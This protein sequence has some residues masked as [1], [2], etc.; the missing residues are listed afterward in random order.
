M[1][2][3]HTLQLFTK[4]VPAHQVVCSP[5]SRLVVDMERFADDAK[6]S[7][8]TKGMGVVYNKTSQGGKLRRQLTNHERQDLLKKW[9][10][11]HH[12]RLTQCV[13]TALSHFGRCL[14][15][16]CH[17]YLSQPLPYEEYPEAQRPQICIG[18]DDV[19]TPQMLAKQ[20]MRY[21]A[22]CG[23]TV[24]E[25]MPFKGALVP[26]TYYG[27]DTRVSALM[28]EIRRDIYMNESN[29]ERHEGF[30]QLQRDI[31]KVCSRFNEGK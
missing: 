8:S 14:V 10:E 31:A 12:L 5:L 17:S 11:P 24:A 20:T 7:M 30:M 26:L 16:D 22:D 29:G 6:E 1:T 23:Y 13:K 9:Y 15:I 28:I 18:T 4:N 25:N 3:H 19:H 2:D 21:F 27:S